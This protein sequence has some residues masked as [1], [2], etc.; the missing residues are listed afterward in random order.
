MRGG[1][2]DLVFNSKETFENMDPKLDELVVKLRHTDTDVRRQTLDELS[3]LE[4][5]KHAIPAIHWTMLNDIDDEIRAYAREI[6]TKM[7][8]QEKGEAPPADTGAAEKQTPTPEEKKEEREERRVHLK[9]V[10]DREPN[11]CGS[12]SIHLSAIALVLIF[13]AHLWNI[14]YANEKMPFLET[15]KLIAFG[16]TIPGL[17]LGLIGLGVTDRKKSTPVAGLIFNSLILLAGILRITG[18]I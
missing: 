7:G 4:D 10:I 12:W 6:Y 15:V 2:R 11:K 3:H 8:E 14:P 18:V 17:I 16:L 1:L 5:K 9:P 13:A